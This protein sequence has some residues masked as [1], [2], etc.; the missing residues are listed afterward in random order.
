M[1]SMGLIGPSVSAYNILQ[2]NDNKALVNRLVT[3]FDLI[4]NK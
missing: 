1:M 3:K 2:P 4:K